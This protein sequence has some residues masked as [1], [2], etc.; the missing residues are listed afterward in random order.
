M[1][2]KKLNIFKNKKDSN[3]Y[4]CFTFANQKKQK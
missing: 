2:L 4:I 1:E 3:I